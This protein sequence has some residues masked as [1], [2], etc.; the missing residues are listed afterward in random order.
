M[1]LLECSSNDGRYYMTY[2]EIL[3]SINWRIFRFSMQLHEGF[4]ILGIHSFMD[5]IKIFVKTYD[6]FEKYILNTFMAT[7]M[8]NSTL[9]GC[10]IDI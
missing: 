9:H 8:I 3:L 10:F 2:F 4:S 1:L 7:A 6:G 5:L